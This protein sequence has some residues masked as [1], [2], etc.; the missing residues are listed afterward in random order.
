MGVGAAWRGRWRHGLR[1]EA[2]KPCVHVGQD[3]QE[4]PGEGRRGK[5]CFC[6]WREFRRKVELL[7]V[8]PTWGQ[9]VS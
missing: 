9:E 1:P 5:G 7:P 6:C 3:Q 8:L 2:L 4:R